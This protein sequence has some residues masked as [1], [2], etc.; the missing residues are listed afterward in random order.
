MVNSNVA[1]LD[2][3][4]GF[5][6][7]VHDSNGNIML[8]MENHISMAGFY[9]AH[10]GYCYFN[11]LS[12]AIVISLSLLWAETDSLILWNLLV[13]KTKYANEIQVF[14]TLF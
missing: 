13:G 9:H 5:G 11:G 2:D 6:V 10:W 1:F 7:V 14:V 8:A 3:D 12:S 4:V